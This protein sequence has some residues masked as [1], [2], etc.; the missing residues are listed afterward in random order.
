VSEPVLFVSERHGYSLLLPDDQW[1]VIERPG[2]WTA[3]TMG[4]QDSLALT[5]SSTQEA[6]S[7]RTAMSCSSTARRSAIR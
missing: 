6:P 7:A 3:G 2:E 5:T 4:S 1:T